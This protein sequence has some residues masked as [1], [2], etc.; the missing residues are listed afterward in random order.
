MAKKKNKKVAKKAI[1]KKS[2]KQEICNC[3][4]KPSGKSKESKVEKLKKISQKQVHKK[5]KGFFRRLFGG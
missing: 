2:K 4:R 1:V 5:K 3:C